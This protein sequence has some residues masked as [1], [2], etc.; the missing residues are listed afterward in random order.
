[1]QRPLPLRPHSVLRWGPQE[2]LP[3]VC[4]TRLGIHWSED[5][6]SS[7][8]PRWRHRTLAHLSNPPPFPTRPYS[9]GRGSGFSV[10]TFSFSTGPSWVSWGHIK[11]K[12]DPA[13]LGNELEMCRNGASSTTLPGNKAIVVGWQACAKERGGF[14][15]PLCPR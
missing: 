3:G 9:T 4:A 8:G 7:Q 1:M 11:P 5:G 12:P 2:G 6:R 10:S 13:H 15:P 14:G